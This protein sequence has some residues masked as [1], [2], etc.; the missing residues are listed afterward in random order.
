MLKVEVRMA[1]ANAAKA[2]RRAAA[3]QEAATVKLPADLGFAAVERLR[4]ELLSVVGRPEVVLDATAVERISTA[5]VLVLV[6]FLNA[7]SEFDPPAAV[8]GPP[9]EFVDAFSELGLFGSLM[10]MEFRT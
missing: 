6:S 2:D 7:R 4:E 8:V 10:R 1:R 5:A 3:P 9:G